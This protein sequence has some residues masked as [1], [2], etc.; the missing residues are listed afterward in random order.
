MMFYHKSVLVRNV[1]N[2]FNFSLW[3]FLGDYW[4][5][6][7][8]SYLDRI[9]SCGQRGTRKEGGNRPLEKYIPYLIIA[10]H[11]LRII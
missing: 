3:Q 8:Q 6:I 2:M 5:I 11:Q 1:F 4:S 9:K 7:L 10:Y